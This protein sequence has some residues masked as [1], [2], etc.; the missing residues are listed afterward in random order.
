MWS[1][2]QFD[3]HCPDS[4]GWFGT[5]L[6]AYPFIEDCSAPKHAKEHATLTLHHT[7]T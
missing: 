4:F 2:Q 5:L 6:L 1:L 3:L 7:E